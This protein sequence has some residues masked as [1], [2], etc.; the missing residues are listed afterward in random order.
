FEGRSVDYV[1]ETNTNYDVNGHIG[2]QLWGN[3]QDQRV[4][5]SQLAAA[6][7]LAAWLCQE[8]DIDPA[9]L[10]G[11]KDVAPGTLCPGLDLYRYVEEGHIERW[12]REKL[13]GREPSITALPPLEDGPTTWIPTPNRPL[14]LP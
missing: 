4:V 3:F 5:E 12:V 11:H 14:E 2:V 1:P 7:D 9:T 6:V 13:A 8:Y 10:S